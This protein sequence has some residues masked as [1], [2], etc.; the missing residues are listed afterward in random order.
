LPAA[1]HG[2]Y[3]L[4]GVPQMRKRPMKPLLDRSGRSRRYRCTG[5]EGFFPAEIRAR[6]LRGWRR[7]NRR[8]RKQPAASALLL[9]AP[10]TEKP[11]E[12][13]LV[14][15]VRWPFVEMTRG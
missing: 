15:G 12:L 6:G 3:Q 2:V 10:L 8:E 5:E 4:D 9:V 14:G 11:V 1:P 7:E 13:T